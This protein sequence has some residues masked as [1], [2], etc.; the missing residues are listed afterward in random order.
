MVSFET[1]KDSC[2]VNVRVSKTCS[3]IYFMNP[4]ILLCGL[5]V[6]NSLNEREKHYFQIGLAYENS[7]AVSSPPNLDM[8][9]AETIGCP[10]C[11]TFSYM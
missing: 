9:Y 1:R 6:L 5:I 2:K 7:L 10:R 8:N 4:F 11:Y 3:L